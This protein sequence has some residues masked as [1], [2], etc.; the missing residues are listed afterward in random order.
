MI[1]TKVENLQGNV[2]FR[3]D[4]NADK[5]GSG[6]SNFSS[7]I[8]MYILRTSIDYD[9]NNSKVIS[10][11]N[12]KSSKVH[13][14]GKFEI[15]L[16][17][18]EAVESKN[19]F[20][21]LSGDL[22]N[23]F[24]IKKIYDT[25]FTTTTYDMNTYI[26]VGKISAKSNDIYGTKIIE[27]LIEY[28]GNIPG[29]STTLQVK[30]Y[31][32]NETFAIGNMPSIKITATYASLVANISIVDSNNIEKQSPFNVTSGSEVYYLTEIINKGNVDTNNVVFLQILDES[33]CN[34]TEV[35]YGYDKNLINILPQNSGS[36]VNFN[37]I[38]SIKANNGSYYV[39]IKATVKL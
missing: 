1:E 24:T 23:V 38:D 9:S 31:E 13:I 4:I 17:N 12:Q 20:I 2:Q 14:L 36:T 26:N 21:N 22:N 8:E 39:R 29:E 6:E 28:T 11:T 18:T 30:S 10:E 25:E 3:Y 34:I 27:V 19:V 7:N 15:I 35:K 32:D 33:S 16:L 37:I 5:D